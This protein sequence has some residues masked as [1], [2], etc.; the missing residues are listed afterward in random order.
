MNEKKPLVSIVVPVYNAE[1]YLPE[2]IGSF[3]G[4][5]YSN[6]E[7]ICVDDSSED[8]SYEI[9]FDYAKRDPRIKVFRKNNSGAAQTRNF[10]ISKAT[11]DFICFVD[12]DDFISSEAI[13]LLVETAIAQQ[14]DVVLFD[15]DNYNETTHSFDQNKSINRKYVPVRQQFRALDVPN[16]Y[17]QIIGFTVNK[18]Y[19]TDFIRE[20]SLEFPE[21]RA[22]ED[23]PFTYLALSLADSIYYLDQTLYHYRRSNINSVSNTLEQNYLFMFQAL[24]CTRDGLVKYGIWKRYRKNFI[25]Y[26]LHMC[27]W[28]LSRKGRLSSIEFLDSSRRVWFPKLS[29]TGLSREDVYDGD[30]FVAYERA[31]SLGKGEMLCAALHRR[32]SQFPLLVRGVYYFRKVYSKVTRRIKH[33][34]IARLILNKKLG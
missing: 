4:Q 22:H 32:C 23:M 33:L 34:K 14:V 7:I 24:E 6:L 12:S 29:L 26:V 18:F 5:S 2:L 19:R 31:I 28:Q 27:S 3:L 21:V 1:K 20:K 25:S 30:D 16:V 10:G 17:K 15:L 13:E 8:S 11:G 9:L